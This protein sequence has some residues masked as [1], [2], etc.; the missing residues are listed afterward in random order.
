MLQAGIQ[1]KHSISSRTMWLRGQVEC[2]CSSHNKYKQPVAYFAP[3]S[4]THILVILPVDFHYLPRKSSFSILNSPFSHQHHS[5]RKG[6]PA[7]P[8]TAIYGP[9]SPHICFPNMRENH[10]KHFMRYNGQFFQ[11]SI[12]SGFG[13]QPADPV[14]CQL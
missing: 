6:L 11:P 3:D 10:K 5:V 7:L 14:D 12:F 13:S 9:V 2:Q 4:E 8:I 1:K